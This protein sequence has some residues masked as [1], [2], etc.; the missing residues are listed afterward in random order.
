MIEKLVTWWA[1][2]QY[3][4]ATSNIKECITITWED[5]DPHVDINWEKYSILEEYLS[6]RHTVQLNEFLLYKSEEIYNVLNNTEGATPSD[7][8][9]TDRTLKGLEE[10]YL[11]S[12][13]QQMAALDRFLEEQTDAKVH[14]YAY[15]GFNRFSVFRP[16][17][18]L[19]SLVRLQI[20]G[21]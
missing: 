15:N 10:L 17:S 20:M 2:R 18:A 6:V 13:N 16:I 8:V 11:D 4:H 21:R 14:T 3:R 9:S 1:I 7:Q 5:G 12:V 19:Y